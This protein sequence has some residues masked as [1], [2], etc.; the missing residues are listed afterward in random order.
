L[1]KLAAHVRFLREFLSRPRGI[2]AVAPS[3]TRLAKE[4]TRGIDWSR[5]QV[6]VEFGPGTGVFTEYILS[7]LPP[8]AKFFV[9]ERNPALADCFRRRYPQV[10]LHEDCAGNI[11]QICQRQGVDQVDCVI[12]GL[13]WAIFSEALQIRLLEALH[14]ILKPG[15]QFTTF[16][17]LQ[18]LLM[19]NG[20]RFR[21]KL[22]VYFTEI[23][24]SPL[25][26][27]NLPPAFVYRCKK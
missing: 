27:L 1:A 21:K 15:G 24:R 22:D 13:P 23:S 2:G 8:Q 9:I 14:S 4:I 18:G 19:P 3:S 16:A 5:V 10:A 7:N 6:A 25:V 26:W 11:R 17:Y 20:R 12:S